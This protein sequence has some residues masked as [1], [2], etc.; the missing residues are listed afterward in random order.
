[1]KVNVLCVSHSTLQKYFKPD[2]QFIIS[3]NKQENY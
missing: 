3:Y 1:M 2:Y